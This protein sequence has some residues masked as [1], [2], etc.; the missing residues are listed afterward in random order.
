MI[1]PQLL[2]AL[3]LLV[4]VAIGYFA[5]SESPAPVETPA[6]ET[7]R[8]PIAD[9]GAAAT[10]AALRARIAE[11]EKQLAAKAPPPPTAET[12][13]TAAAVAGRDRGG[14]FPR[15]N[16]REWMENLKKN[17]PVRY[18]EMTN[19]ISR[20]RS[21]RAA[22]NRASLDFLSSIDTSRMSASAK[23]THDELQELMARREELETEMMKEDISDERRHEI[24]KELGETHR[25]LRKLQSEERANLLSET[26]KSL[27]FEGE[28]VETISATI[29]D[30]IDATSGGRGGPMGGPPP[31]GGPQPPA[32]GMPAPPAGG[33]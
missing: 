32:G 10:I 24:M 2:I 22:Q 15:G 26:A 5:K 9:Q 3:A 19:R 12:N 30:V 1:K 13:A 17:D 29:Q 31:G 16:P 21:D 28:D 20:W 6:E 23:A 25:E 33:K 4:G 18:A 7:L 11:L 14:F 8:K 27:G